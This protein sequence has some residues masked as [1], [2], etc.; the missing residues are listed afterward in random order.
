MCSSDLRAF[1]TKLG[2]AT[3]TV[4]FMGGRAAT[5]ATGVTEIATPAGALEIDV[6][7]ENYKGTV[8]VSVGEGA[9]ATSEVTLTEAI[10]KPK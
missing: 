9:T 4:P 6:S 1:V 8:Q 2:G 10:E 5:D 7:A 3:I